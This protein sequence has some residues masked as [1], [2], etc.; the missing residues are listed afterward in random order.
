LNE[1]DINRKPAL[2]DGDVTSGYRFDKIDTGPPRSGSVNIKSAK[3]A[4]VIEKV[5]RKGT[6]A[7]ESAKAK[8][9]QVISEKDRLRLNNWKYKPDDELYL[10]YKDVFDNP[11][12]YNQVTGEINWPPND[13]FLNIPVDETLKP[14]MR[15]S[16]YG[17]DEGSFAS[18][19]S[20]PYEMRATAPGTDT[21]PYS[22]FEL[23][24]P[25]K[26]KEGE[27]APWF[28]EPGG[29]LQY[30]FQDSVEDMLTEGK[31]RRISQ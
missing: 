28:D 8:I 2:A 9:N 13:G 11:K 23:V 7:A 1:T 21:K 27:T 15:I 5:G 22:V 30:I 25:I 14:G 10:K 3:K 20:I 16:R 17:F 19:E 26:V 31:I 29:G 6:D 12:Y 4:E 24:E 18:P